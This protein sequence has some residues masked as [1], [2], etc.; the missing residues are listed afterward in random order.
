MPQAREG[1]YQHNLRSGVQNVTCGVQCP[2]IS[3][4]LSHDADG[5]LQDQQPHRTQGTDSLLVNN[6]TARPT[7]CPPSSLLLSAH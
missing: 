5:S 1:I 4:L 6:V 2:Y 3:F 7:C